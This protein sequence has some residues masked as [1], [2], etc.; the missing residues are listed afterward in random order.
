MTESRKRVLRK[1]ALVGVLLI[2]FALRAYRLGAESLWYDETVSVHLAS[3]SAAELIR[4]TAGDIHPPG[5]YLLLRSWSLLGGD[6]DYSAAFLSLFFGVL[7]VALAHRIST[8]VFSSRVG[9][10]ASLLVALSPYHLW[11]SQEVRM[12]TLGAALGLIVLDALFSMLTTDPRGA[13]WWRAFGIYAV[14]G[15]FGLWVLYYFAFLLV[16]INLMVAVWWLVARRHEDQGLLWLRRW[17]LAQVAVLLLFLPWMPAAW[18]QVI[19]PPVPPWRSAT[20]LGALAVESWSALSLGQSLVPAKA[21]PILFLFVVLFAL[22]IFAK[23]SPRASPRRARS[24]GESRTTRKGGIGGLWGE[25][26]QEG[27]RPWF[28]A[29]YVL[30][31][32]VLIYAASLLT[33]LYHVRYVF[34][35]SPPFYILLAA[36]VVSLGRWLRPGGWLALG[37]ILTFFAWSI[38][39]YHTQPEFASD[40]HRGATRFL[41]ERWRPGDAIL[42]NAGYAYTALLSYWDGEPISWRGRLTG[43][44][45]DSTAGGPVIVQTGSVG[46]DPSL[47]WGSPASD[48]YAISQ[49]E[50]ELALARLFGAFD[51]VW[52]YR[53]YDTVTD[54]EGMIR[55]WLA[56]EGTQFEDQAFTGKSQLRVQGFLTRRA[57]QDMTPLGDEW[58]LEDGSLTLLGSEPIEPVA[59]PGGSLGLALWWRVHRGVDEGTTLFAGLFDGSGRRWAQTDEHPMG[60]EYPVESWAAGGSERTPLRLDVPPGTPP[61]TY[62]LQVG[63]YRFEDGVPTWLPWEDGERL[64]IGQVQVQAP[65][66]WLQ[67]PQAQPEYPLRITIGRSVE[68]LGFDAPSFNGVPGES[69]ELELYWQAQGEAPEA[70]PAVLRLEDDSGRVYVETGSAPAAGAVPFVQLEPG[71]QVRDSRKLALPSDLPSGVYGVTIGRRQNSGSWLP[72][73]RGAFSLGIRYPLATI[74]VSGRVMDWTRPAPEVE[75]GIQFGDGILLEGVDLIRDEHGLWLNLYWQA[76]ALVDAPLKLFVHAVGEGGPSDIRAQVDEYPHVPTTGWVPGEFLED[77][78]VVDIPQELL[79]SNLTLM[80]GWYDESTGVRLTAWS[81][82]GQTLGTAFA[83]E[84]PPGE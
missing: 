77:S 1:W 75:T 46:G 73:R 62:E 53:V 44:F 36:G 28:L 10:V 13:V 2:A 21:W 66:D 20:G 43:A 54:P 74:R 47:G 37:L 78:L 42:V 83:L 61:G 65:D 34:A 6:T 26:A 68:L 57:T 56:H 16:A 35:F 4:H 33:P 12:Y 55:R 52:V 60:S 29:G 9:L 38:H 30:V 39:A 19:Q 82:S 84:I 41:A 80:I 76:L 3:K 7:I 8:R 64:T 24:G 72:V 27:C 81:A 71:E 79:D 58:S 40:D 14:C 5:Y 11:Y 51:R 25:P 59:E 45:D 48:F 17:L 31:P 70:G 67:V 32:V 15:A 18:R 23:D 69:L 50:T 63:W 22:G 49:V